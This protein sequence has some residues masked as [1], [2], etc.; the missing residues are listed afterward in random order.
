MT[1]AKTENSINALLIYA[2]IAL[3]CLA[4]TW[5]YFDYQDSTA[6]LVAPEPLP[7]LQPLT[8]T[9]SDDIAPVLNE[10]LDASLGK[11]RLAAEANMLTEPAGEN[12]L[13]FYGLVLNEDHMHAEAN[14][15][16]DAILETLYAEV[17]D[18]LEANEY[19]AAHRV[20]EQVAYLRP[21]HALVADTA[22]VLRQI[23]TEGFTEAIEHAT[24]GDRDAALTRLEEVAALPGTD[25]DATAQ[26]QADIESELE[27]FAANEAEQLAERQRAETAAAAQE[28]E[29]PSW[30]V[31]ARAAIAEGRL[32]EPPGNNAREYLTQGD[33]ENAEELQAQLVSALLSGSE[34]AARE[35]DVDTATTLFEALSELEPDNPQLESAAESIKMARVRALAETPVSP[36]DLTRRNRV[37]PVYP[38][39]AERRRISGWVDMAFTVTNEGST[40]DIEILNSEPPQ[41][42]EQAVIQ[43]ASQWLF[44]PPVIEGISVNRRVMTRIVFEIPD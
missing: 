18:N 43:A 21:E 32:I 24:R 38:R 10:E 28:R 4:A 12:A 16:I 41:V 2:A 8:S 6:E 37:A 44:E 17:T 15:E 23:R 26:V 35:G 34:R 39:A 36:R 11:A 13:Y 20:A 29:V 31:N 22:R 33:D 40:T 25:P 3:A 42:F 9:A 5:V 27:T 14:E 1:V 7:T 19:A 30:L